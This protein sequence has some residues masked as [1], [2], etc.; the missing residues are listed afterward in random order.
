MAVD[1]AGGIGSGRG[2][3]K[4]SWNLHDTAGQDAHPLS[5]PAALH[6]GPI[7][8]A[9]MNNDTNDSP[10]TDRLCEVAGRDQA[11]AAAL[12]AEA[13]KLLKLAEALELNATLAV[14]AATDLIAE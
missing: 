11:V 9:A 14:S 3:L 6:P 10:C 1:L 8:S 12:R 2:G 4:L 13:A 7:A 5:G